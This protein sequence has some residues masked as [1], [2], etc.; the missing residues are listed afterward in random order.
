MCGEDEVVRGA[1]RGSELAVWMDRG[2]LVFTGRVVSLR[3]FGFL[4]GSLA[5]EMGGE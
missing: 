5:F 3:N 2:T 1:G 4:S